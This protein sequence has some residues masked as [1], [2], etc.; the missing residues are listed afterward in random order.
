MAEGQSPSRAMDARERLQQLTFSFAP[1]RVLMTAL[2]LDLFS[3]IA[4]GHRTAAD[5]ARAAG[6]NERGTRMVLD[7]LAGLELL[8]KGGGQ[9]E[10]TPVARQYLARG[11]SDYMG[12]MLESERLWEAWAHLTEVVKSGKP[13]RNV[14]EQKDAEDFFKILVRSLHVTNRPL[15]Q[16]ATEALG[17][18]TTRRGLRVLDIGCGSGVWGISIAEADEEARVTA[19]DFPKVLEITREYAGRHKVA[20]RF[21]YLPGDL[22]E[23]DLGENRYDV[24]VLG[25]I[26]HSEGERS[27]RA[28]FRRIHRALRPGGRL[29]IADMI[30]NDERTGPPFAL[31]F[32]INMLLNTEEG[33]TFTLAEYK[34][35]LTEAGFARVETAD[36]GSHSPL[37]I[38]H[39]A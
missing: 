18:G 22:R 17:A 10:L 5:I 6:A 35:W 9:Y 25:N 34:A 4:A 20:G 30:P 11:S 19:L 2:Q 14:T 37:L 28:L 15:A 24:A 26:A 23:A 21:E 1:T 12:S 33:D 32:A 38:A 29:A 7:A 27:S 39:R 13:F 3:H 16:R 8:T 36:I 31:I